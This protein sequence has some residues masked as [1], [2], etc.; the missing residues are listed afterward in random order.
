M[1]KV[2][3]KIVNSHFGHRNVAEVVERQDGVIVVTWDGGEIAMFE[4]RAA[5]Y[6]WTQNNRF[7]SAIQ[8]I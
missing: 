4:N 7:I 3:A 2:I 1:D 8:F 6:P 5:F